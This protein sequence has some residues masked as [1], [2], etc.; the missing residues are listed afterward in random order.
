MKDAGDGDGHV[1]VS[2]VSY[3][4]KLFRYGAVGSV[5]IAVSSRSVCRM[6]TA[7]ES[8]MVTVTGM[9]MIFAGLH[10]GL[11]LAS[12]RGVTASMI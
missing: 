5:E 6:R 8:T 1:L 11:V 7:S 2:N 12:A 3:R 9:S 10:V 4:T